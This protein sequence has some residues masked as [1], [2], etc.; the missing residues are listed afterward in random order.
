[1][2][3]AD[4]SEGEDDT[5]VSSAHASD[6]KRHARAQHNALERRRRNNIKDMYGA[7][8]DAVPGMRNERASRAVVLKKSVELIK[9]KKAA[10]EKTLALN[11]K[12]EEENAILEREIEQIKRA[13][14]KQ[15]TETVSADANRKTNKD[16]LES[17]ATSGSDFS[18]LS[19]HLNSPN[20]KRP[21]PSDDQNTTPENT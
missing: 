6:S 21:A 10:L 9:M 20:R 13:A 19:V 16:M 17:E 8:K 3:D 18:R 4:F 2:S 15:I 14:G 11:R 5:A 12:L 7:L 1:M